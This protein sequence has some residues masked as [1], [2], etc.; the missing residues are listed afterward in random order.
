MRTQII[1]GL[2]IGSNKIRV[3]VAQYTPEDNSIQIIGA[4]ENPSNG[5][6][7]GNIVSVEDVVSSISGTL[8][9][10]ERV[11]GMPIERAI[12]GIS[13]PN[14]KFINSQGVIAVAKADGEIKE[15][16]VARV[17]EAAQAVATPPNYEILHVIPKTYKVDNQED[18]K[19][20][21]GMTGVRLEVSAQIIMAK[22]EQIKTITKC[23]YRTGVDVKDMVF[24]VLA[25]AEA[26]LNREQRELGVVL[27]NIGSSTT[28]VAIFEEGDPIHTAILPIGSSHITNDLAI[29][30]RTS[31]GVAEKIKIQE[32]S[33][34]I[35]NIR[36]REEI[37]LSVFEEDENTTKRN[38]VSKL[39]IAKITNARV[40]EIF[41]L[42]AK[43]LK[44]VDRF[45][46]L[47]AG[48]V[49]TGGGA[50]LDGMV[51]QAKEQLK[52]PVFL[53]KM[54]KVNTIV[55]KIND[56]TYSN[57]LG[58]ILWGYKNK[59][60]SGWNMGGLLKSNI[61]SKLKGFFKSLIP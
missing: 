52:L 5:I 60:V 59:S 7:N 18:I 9:K 46:M 41:D 30:L 3:A 38:M 54:N 45:G 61:P 2:D 49:L 50:K 14:I 8:E 47:P 19:D 25:D 58:L 32:A 13:S 6:I 1:T 21:I 23:I 36:K 33:C 44:K 43:E 12:I 28:G 35:D 40:E 17:I 48:V 16:D 4:A 42:V 56:L 22:S 57:V 51:E 11:I 26:V 53:A 34:V 39:E 55:D 20:P 10:V 15:E 29:G 37:N 27:V 31:I 24:S